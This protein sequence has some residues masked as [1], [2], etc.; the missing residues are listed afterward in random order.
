MTNFH[1]A[2][3]SAWSRD[4][5][6]I[7]DRGRAYHADWC[8]RVFAPALTGREGEG[9]VRRLAEVIALTDVYL[10]KVLRH[11]R[12]LSRAQTEL[13][14]YELIEPLMGGD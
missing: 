4:S 2:C 9:R 6:E 14:L 5:S 7:A 11:D 13:A 12:R 10:W 3:Q 1:P 8:E